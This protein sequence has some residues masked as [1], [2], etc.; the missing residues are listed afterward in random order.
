MAPLEIGRHAQ[1]RRLERV[2]IRVVPDARF[3]CDHLQMEPV[4]IRRFAE[5][6]RFEIGIQEF[7]FGR[8]RDFRER[9]GRRQNI[10]RNER[11]R[12]DRRGRGREGAATEAAVSALAAWTEVSSGEGEDLGAD[13][14]AA[15]DH[16]MKIRVPKISSQ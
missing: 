12:L 8:G 3:Q 10:R 1:C 7:Q 14:A 4:F 11:G 13:G 2:Q 16:P 6:R 5:G 9:V 15:G